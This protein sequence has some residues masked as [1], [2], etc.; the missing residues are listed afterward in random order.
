MQASAKRSMRVLPWVP[1]LVS[2]IFSQ[3]VYIRGVVFAD[4]F[5]LLHAPLLQCCHSLTWKNPSCARFSPSCRCCALRSRG[6]CLIAAFLFLCTKTHVVTFVVHF[7]LRLR[8]KLQKRG[9]R[10]IFLTF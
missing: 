5:L 2:Q 10:V 6:F 1:S 8:P 3:R 4:A 9:L 7:W